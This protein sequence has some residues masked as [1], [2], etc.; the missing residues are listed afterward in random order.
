MSLH[1]A[2]IHLDLAELARWAG[3]RGW[4]SAGRIEHY[5][6]GAVLHHLL[7]ESFGRRAL[8]PFRLMAPPGE[9]GANLY[10]YTQSDAEALQRISAAV[11]LP[12]TA[13]ILDTARIRSKP[14]PSGWAAG[15]RLGFDVRLR[16]VVRQ[17]KAKGGPVT[18]PCEID[19]F[20]AEAGRNH[21]GDKAGMTRA[22][23]GREEVYSSWLAA[24]LEGAALLETVRLVRFRHNH[25][26][27]NGRIIEGPDAII[28]GSLTIADPG[29]FRSALAGGIGR[30]RAYG[31]GMILLR[32]PDT[33]VPRGQIKRPAPASPGWTGHAGAC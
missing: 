21:P 1:L 23:R 5:D 26:V 32:P 12:E 28:H 15:Q 24:R 29:I 2:R 4:A 17:R 27:R 20:L 6:E 18:K 9:R 33:R 3:D 25:A 22:G 16:P 11:S 8:Q 7:V 19:A 14:V 31:Y 10:A 30:H 13:D